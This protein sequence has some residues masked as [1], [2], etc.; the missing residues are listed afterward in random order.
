MT[1][2]GTDLVV[3]PGTEEV[4]DLAAM[5]REQLAAHRGHL[6]ELSARVDFA[7]RLF[8]REI[9]RRIDEENAVSGSGYTWRVA[10]YKITVDSPTVAGKLDVHALRAYLVATYSDLDL[11]ALFDRKVTYTLRHDRWKNATKQHPEFDDVLKDHQ[12]PPRRD[13]KVVPLPQLHAIDAT[14]E[15]DA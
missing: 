6:A 11:D 1:T 13:V 7:K 15:D 2:P 4:L 5:D 9:T 3:M 10:G 12:A 8:N 14:S